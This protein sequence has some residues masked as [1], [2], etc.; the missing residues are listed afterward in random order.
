M[1]I[2]LA[3]IFDPSVQRLPWG[4]KKLELRLMI[5]I[6]MMIDDDDSNY[7]DDDW[8]KQVWEL[9]ASCRNRSL[10]T[11]FL[12]CCPRS[13]RAILNDSLIRMLHLSEYFFSQFCENDATEGWTYG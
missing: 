3:R 1:S 10:S 11:K 9:A 7:D 4:N 6:M 13:L 8:D 12:R 2:I 5:M